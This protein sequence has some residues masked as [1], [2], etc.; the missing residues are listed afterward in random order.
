MEEVEEND[1][2]KEYISEEEEA[3]EEE[4]DKDDD[5]KSKPTSQVLHQ[6]KQWTSERTR[7]IMQKQREKWLGTRVNIS[8]W[9]HIVIGISRKYLNGRFATDEAIEDV[10]LDGHDEGNINGDHCT[11]LTT[12]PAH[13]LRNLH[14]ISHVDS[15]AYVLGTV[16]VVVGSSDEVH[17][18][19]GILCGEKDGTARIVVDDGIAA[20]W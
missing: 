9:R 8:A 4:D 11:R 10:D 3:E 20:K 18:L 12:I 2:D 17:F 14:G 1:D 13:V 16:P 15:N 6:S 5:I 19:R 7:K